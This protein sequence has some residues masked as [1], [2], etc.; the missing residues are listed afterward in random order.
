MFEDHLLPGRPSSLAWGL[1]VLEDEK[2]RG[3]GGVPRRVRR[4][5]WKESVGSQ[6]VSKPVSET[7]PL[8]DKRVIKEKVKESQSYLN[9]SF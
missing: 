4:A 2:V 3:R 5:T 7:E 9:T 8:L 6:S 1:P